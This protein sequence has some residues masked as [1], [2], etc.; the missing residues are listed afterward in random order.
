MPNLNTRRVT[1][2]DVLSKIRRESLLQWLAPATE[3]LA[4]RGVAPAAV[5]GATDG[6]DG[7]RVLLQG[8]GRV[9]STVLLR[10]NK[11]FA[12]DEQCGVS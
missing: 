9:Q 3:Y 7:F 5:L 11:S 2:P 1:A 8:N 6:D 10:A 4:S 12:V